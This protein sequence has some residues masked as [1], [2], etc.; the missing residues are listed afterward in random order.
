[1]RY[2]VTGGTGFLGRAIVTKLLGQ[3]HYVKVL[4]NNFRGKPSMLPSSLSLEVVQGDIRDPE[5]V[6]AAGNGIDSIIHLAFINGTR[7][8]Y[9]QPGLVV[10][11]GIRGMLNVA[12]SARKNGVE[13]LVLFST[14]ETYQSPTLIPTPEDVPLVVPD[15]LNP[16]YSYGGAKIASEL[17][18]VNYCTS[19]L[20][21]WRIIRPHNIYGPKMGN[22]HV[23]PNLISKIKHND[24]SISIQGDGKQTRSFCHVKDF[25]SAFDLVIKPSTPDGIYN[26]GVESEIQIMDLTK[27]LMRLMGKDLSVEVTSMNIGETIRRCPDISKI[28]NLGFKPKIDLENG[29]LTC[30]A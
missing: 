27:M 29:L 14:S 19:F 2:L 21:S 4:D 30:L 1:M 17:Y 6:E 12:E 26:I 10:D 25:V 23:I 8:F 5:C 9:E 28:R 16:R 7:H 22:D 15:V 18:L 3:G 13:E 24:R 11:V 20:K